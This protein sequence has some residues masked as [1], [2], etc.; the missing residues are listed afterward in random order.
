MDEKDKLWL[1]DHPLPR[2]KCHKEVWALKISAVEW[3]RPEATDKQVPGGR[4]FPADTNYPPFEVSTGYLQKHTPQPGGYWVSYKDGYQSFSPA[5]QFEDGYTLCGTS[6]PRTEE[7]ATDYRYAGAVG[8]SYL[9][10]AGIKLEAGAGERCHHGAYRSEVVVGLLGQDIER[11]RCF[12]CGRE[13]TQPSRIPK[14]WLPEQPAP[15]YIKPETTIALDKVTGKEAFKDF[16]KRVYVELD[17]LHSKRTRLEFFI[18][19]NPE[20]PVLPEDERSRLRS[21]LSIML[22][23]EAIL[24]ERINHFPKPESAQKLDELA[25]GETTT[26]DE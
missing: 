24:Q 26:K 21:Q 11:C 6:G 1:G 8:Q 17:E 22:D 18:F 10:A 20:F 5:E 12:Q 14:E 4:L 13:W 3:Y 15:P 2:Y 9:S 7:Q 19:Q 16:E 25:T 23:Y